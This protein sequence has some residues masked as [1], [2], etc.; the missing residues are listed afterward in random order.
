MVALLG[1]GAAWLRTVEDLSLRG[2]VFG[3][4][5]PQELVEEY[6]HALIAAAPGLTSL[7]KLCLYHYT[8]PPGLMSQLRLAFPCASITNK[9]DDDW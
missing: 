7:T 2:H 5:V 6:V 1:G 3:R 8:V 9:N 4:N